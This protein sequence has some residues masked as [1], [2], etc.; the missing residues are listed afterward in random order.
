MK[1]HWT[2]QRNSVGSWYVLPLVL[3]EFDYEPWCWW[4]LSFGWLQ[5]GVNL[6]ATKPEPT[7]DAER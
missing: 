6:I 4:S 1:Y 2:Y 7:G 3:L 5:W